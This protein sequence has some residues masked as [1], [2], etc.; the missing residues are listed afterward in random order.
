MLGAVSHTLDFSCLG[1]SSSGSYPDRRHASSDLGLLMGSTFPSSR[2]KLTMDFIWLSMFAIF[3][4]T[5]VYTRRRVSNGETIY[6]AF[7]LL[8][9]YSQYI[10]CISWCVTLRAFQIGQMASTI[11]IGAGLRE[12]INTED[13]C[14]IRFRRGM[15]HL[16]RRVF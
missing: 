3:P 1:I 13:A 9:R 6:R 4:D 12:I 2:S 5:G 10:L 16:L 11:Y 14:G 15:W 7:Q 8:E